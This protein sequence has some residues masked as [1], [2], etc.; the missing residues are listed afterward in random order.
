VLYVFGL[1][2][3]FVAAPNFNTPASNPYLDEIADLAYQVNVMSPEEVLPMFHPQ[4]YAISDPNLSDT[5]FPEMEMLQR[6]TLTSDKIYLCF[7]AQIIAFFVGS[8]SDP[9]LIS[10]L[11]KVNSY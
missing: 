11:F 1:L 4:I 10:Q 8:Q 7:N 6:Q 3:S 9:S 2:K 5:E